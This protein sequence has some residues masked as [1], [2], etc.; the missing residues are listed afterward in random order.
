MR[1]EPI[2]GKVLINA[3]DDEQQYVSTYL[4]INGSILH[5]ECKERHSAR[6]L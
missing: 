2:L 3:T 5:A 6:P 1:V 4:V